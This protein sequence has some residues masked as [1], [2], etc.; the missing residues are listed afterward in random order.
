MRNNYNCMGDNK[1]YLLIEKNV[2]ES[3]CSRVAALSQKRRVYEQ[4]HLPAPQYYNNKEVQQLLNVDDKLIR[5]YRDEG[6]L[7]H[8]KVEGKYWYNQKD[9]ADFL[10]KN[11]YKSFDVKP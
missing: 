8:T 7:G 5:K 1:E 2:W 6:L 9:V 3:V 4:T 10:E 11:K